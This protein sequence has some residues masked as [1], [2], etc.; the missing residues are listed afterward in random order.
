MKLVEI[1][2]GKFTMGSSKAEQ[3]KA[4][5]E[6]KRRLKLDKSAEDICANDG[7]AHKVT[8]TRPFNMGIHEVTRRQFAAFVIATDYKTEAEKE[9]KALGWDGMKFAVMEGY[10]WKKT[11]FDQTDAHPVVNVSWNDARE[12]CK[13]LSRKSGRKVMLPTEAQWE[14]ACRGQTTTVYPWGDDPNDGKGWCNVA[15]Q[16]VKDKFSVVTAFGFGDGCLFTAPVGQFKPNAFGLYDMIGNACEWC[17]DWYSESYANAKNVDPEGPGSGSLRLM[18]GGSWGFAPAD[19][20]SASRVMDSPGHQSVSLGFRVVVLEG[21]A[22]NEHAAAIVPTLSPPASRPFPQPAKERW[23]SG[24]PNYD[25]HIRVVASERGAFTGVAK[26][27]QVNFQ[28]IAVDDANAVRRAII[29]EREKAPQKL[30]SNVRLLLQVDKA[31]SYRGVLP[32]LLAA[33]DCGFQQVELVEPLPGHTQALDVSISENSAYGA[34]GISQG[35][36]VLRVIGSSDGIHS[37]I[38]IRGD[39]VYWYPHELYERLQSKL[40]TME[41]KD[42]HAV[43]EAGPQVSW[44]AVRFAHEQAVRAGCATVSLA[45]CGRQAESEPTDS[46]VRRQFI[47]RYTK[48]EEQID[49]GKTPKGLGDP[50]AS[51]LTASDAAGGPKSRFFGSGGNAY[52]IVY[53]VDRSGSMAPT[54]EQVRIEML[55]SISQLQRSQDFTIIL[56]SDSKYIEGPQ[57]RL[58]SAELVNK[59]AANTFLKDITANGSTTVLPALKRAFQV[60]KDTDASKPGRLIYLLSNGDFAGKSSGSEYT[61]ADGKVLKGNE[62]VIQWLRDNN[63]K[64]EKKGLMHVYTFLYLSKDEE[65]KKLMETIAKE[66]GGRFK[67][68]TADE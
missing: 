54:F 26:A 65:A 18:R 31:A 35:V 5:E 42:V 17:S 9:G 15:D 62:A 61:S 68:I 23:L 16:M 66:N 47:K 64:D 59:L 50:A 56:F 37:V 4:G 25:I 1:P 3:A 67:L 33:R 28:T 48:R 46:G 39:S 2:A 36:I 43:I 34:A 44:E 60:L 30:R 24:L 55:K 40:K 22:V 12:F 49:E 63:P 41:I 32:I 58:V 11:G 21:A 38:E 57:K 19:C 10:S 27:Y 7:P 8:L 20:R 14:Y 29:L 52:H 45:K 53:V 6:T 13:W 51:G